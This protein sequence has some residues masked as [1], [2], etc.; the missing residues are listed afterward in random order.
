[1]TVDLPGA[2]ELVGPAVRGAAS[3]IPKE[4]FRLTASS[5]SPALAH[6]VDGDPTTRWSTQNPQAGTEWLRIVFDAPRDIVRLRL[7]VADR[8]FWD[9]PRELTVAS[10]EGKGAITLYKGRPL[11]AFLQGLL[12]EPAQAPLEIS[13]PPN[14]TSRLVLMQTGRTGSAWWS[15]HELTLWER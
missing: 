11:G 13:L 7:D 2:P 12:R 9:Y 8:S 6:L 5:D 15:I 1:V 14:S 3:K 4:G 10:G